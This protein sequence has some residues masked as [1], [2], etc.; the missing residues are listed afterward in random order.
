MPLHPLQTPHSGYH[1]D[2]KDHR[3]FEGWYFRLTLPETRQTFAFMYSIEDPV[4]GQP[5][6][7]GTAQI[8]GPKDGYFCR[9]FPDPQKFWAWP[10][11]LGLG[12]WRGDSPAK[13]RLLSGTEFKEHIT[14]GYQVTATWHQGYLNDPVLGPVA[15]EYHTEPIYGWASTGQPQQ[16][17]AGLLSSLQIF[18]PGWQ[19]L[20]AHGHSTGWIEWQGERYEFAN[21]PAYSEKNWGR[22]FPQKWFW[23]NCNAFE[24]VPDLALTAGGGRRQVLAWMESVAMVG[25]HHGGKF[26]EFVPWNARVTWHITPWGYWHMRCDR[27]DYVVEVTGTTNL[28]G[29]PLRAPTHNGMAFC[30][31]D[32]ALGDL[33]LKL[34][35]RRGSALD[36]VVAATS[37]Q[38]G[39]EVGGGPWDEPW[40][41]E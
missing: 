17:T 39:L 41:K 19:I 9:T 27:L 29:I 37:T 15:W 14:E 38:A 32:T 11:G 24:G 8:L 36:L 10:E 5:H 18:E 35:Q 33:S 26:Y 3:F 22:S 13:P 21:A 25:V 34:W 31:R 30:C 40:V 20:M 28:P 6:S 2:G 16:S 12:H 23:L 1:W 4:G 7:G